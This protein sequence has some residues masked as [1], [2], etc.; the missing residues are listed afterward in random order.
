MSLATRYIIALPIILIMGLGSAFARQPAQKLQFSE[1]E[2][3]IPTNEA[4]VTLAGTLSVPAGESQKPRPA[5]VLITSAGGQ[6]RDQVVSGVPMLKI[7]A[8]R[9]A[10]SGFVVLRMDDRGTGASTGPSVWD[11]TT[12][13]KAL[14]MLAAVG[15]LKK[16]PEV[17]SRVIGLIGHSEGA[18]VAPMV[19]IKDPD[20]RFVV[21]LGSPG[22]SGEEI[23]NRQ[24]TEE[25][26][27]RTKDPSVLA[28]LEAERRRMIAYIKSGNKDDE[29][30]YRL[31]HDYFAAFRMPESANTRQMTDENFGFLRKK[32]F[33]FFF[34]NNPIQNLKKLQI[35]TLVVAGAADEQV[36]P[37]QN[38]VPIISA[39]IEAKNPDFSVA[40]IP[41]QDH[42]FVVPE[43]RDNANKPTLS[44]TL[45]AT[46]SDWIVKHRGNSDHGK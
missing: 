46:V 34:A 27:T 44:P 21:L 22:V 3:R 42:F 41:R 18:M 38:L 23:W 43:D 33:T 16:L 28:A 19:A 36:A 26:K 14:D 2:V 10:E 31:G 11:S 7:L 8:A 35:P 5:I 4:N 12:A 25:A 24:Q 37:E 1:K 45:L 9:L 30:F 13:D 40:V 20:V 15:F 39:L 32:W 29:A 17:D 6:T